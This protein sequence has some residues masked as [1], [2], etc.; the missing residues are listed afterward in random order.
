VFLGTIA[1]N[2]RLAR[3]DA[4]EADLWHVIEAVE[5]GDTVRALPDG[6]HTRL[7]ERGGNLSGGQLQRLALA[8]ALLRR[9][10]LLICDEVT[11][12]LDAAT[13]ARLLERLRPELAGC[14]VVW[15]THRPATLHLADQVVV[16]EDGRIAEVRRG[17]AVTSP[18]AEV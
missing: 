3:P 18:R 12:Q 6:L 13:E 7:T 1:E 14:T 17:D 15:I 8:Q 16:L 5:L 4:G 10:A 2:L 9:P 11:G